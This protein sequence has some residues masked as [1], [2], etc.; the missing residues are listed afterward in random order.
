[1]AYY[2]YDD[3]IFSPENIIYGTK[4]DIFQGMIDVCTDNGWVDLSN[5][6]PADMDDNVPREASDYTV[7]YNNMEKEGPITV[8]ICPFVDETHSKNINDIRTTSKISISMEM[9]SEYQRPRGQAS[10]GTFLNTLGFDM[11]STDWFGLTLGTK[12]VPNDYAGFALYYY[13][14]PFLCMFILRDDEGNGNNTQP[15]FFG[16]GL[17]HD[18]YSEITPQRSLITFGNNLTADS[19]YDLSSTIRWGENVIAMINVPE[20][21]GATED[22][23]N[24]ASIYYF[25]PIK[26]PTTAS[27]Y[28]LT[29]ILYGRNQFSIIAEIPGIYAITSADPRGL[30]GLDDGAH[31]EANGHI[32]EVLKSTSPYTNMNIKHFAYRIE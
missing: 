17:P 28:I 32:Y 19:Y 22:N 29:P 16:W 26:N 9:V 3:V 5:S 30:G 20:P 4:G 15:V 18:K 1:M 24:E 11:I 27:R 8:R 23:L 31:I 13:V 7:L 25:E 6:Y 14:S 21:F 10:V 2:D 12:E